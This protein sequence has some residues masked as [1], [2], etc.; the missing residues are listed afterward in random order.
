MIDLYDLA[1]YIY[2]YIYIY[3]MNNINDDLPCL[4]AYN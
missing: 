3:I 4:G 1:L 2:I